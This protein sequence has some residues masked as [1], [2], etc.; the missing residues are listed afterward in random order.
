MAI[1]IRVPLSII[2]MILIKK[3]CGIIAQDTEEG[4]QL[5]ASDRIG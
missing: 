2:I 1:R 4:F 3:R 5:A